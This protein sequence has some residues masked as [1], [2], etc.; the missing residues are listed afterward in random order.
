MD[1]AL[2][3]TQTIGGMFNPPERLGSIALFVLTGGWWMGCDLGLVN[4]AVTVGGEHRQRVLV[5]VLLPAGA[6]SQTHSIP[7]I[8][9]SPPPL[10]LSPS[11]I[12]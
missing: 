12:P 7:F 9:C 8:I 4:A 2:G 10:F 1:V 11:E 6:V 5:L 3:T